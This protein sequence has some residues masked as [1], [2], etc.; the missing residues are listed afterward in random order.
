MKTSKKALEL[1]KKNKKILE[2]LIAQFNGKLIK[3]QDALLED[4]KSEIDGLKEEIETDE[5]NKKKVRVF[6]STL[7]GKLVALKKKLEEQI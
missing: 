5:R 6:G 7:V 2:R 4:L 1:L 3:G